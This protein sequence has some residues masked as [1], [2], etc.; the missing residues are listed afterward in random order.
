MYRANIQNRGRVQDTGGEE[1]EKSSHGGIGRKDD[2]KV[3]DTGKIGLCPQLRLAVVEKNQGGRSDQ[4]KHA[5]RLR[6]QGTIV[7]QEGGRVISGRQRSNGTAFRP[8]N[9]RAKRPFMAI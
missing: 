8:S 7:A 5:G 4:G 3:K 1:V 2:R 6:D 9:A